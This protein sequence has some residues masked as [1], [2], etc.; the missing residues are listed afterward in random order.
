M[1]K[2]MRM[3]TNTHTHKHTHTH[4]HTHNIYL[5]NDVYQ[6]SLHR[7][8]HLLSHVR[9]PRDDCPSVLLACNMALKQEQMQH[10]QDTCL[11]SK[12]VTM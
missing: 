8:P 9:A 12:L 3:R 11:E 10:M 1:G 2:S 7:H 5:H 4:T 6:P